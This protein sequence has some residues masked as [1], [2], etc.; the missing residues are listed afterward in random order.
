M[1]DWIWLIIEFVVVI[2]MGTIAAIFAWDNVD[3]IKNMLHTAIVKPHLQEKRK[4]REWIVLD[5]I[6]GAYV[7]GSNIYDWAVGIS[8]SRTDIEC[9]IVLKEDMEN[10]RKKTVRSRW[11]HATYPVPDYDYE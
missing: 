11:E 3:D 9:V 7:G 6:T 5:K 4:E 10:Y 1:I 8:K 2:T